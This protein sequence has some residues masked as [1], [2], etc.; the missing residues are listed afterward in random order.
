MEESRYFCLNA[1][2]KPIG[3]FGISQLREKLA[4]GTIQPDSYVA[5]VGGSAWVKLAE[6]LP[7]LIKRERAE[8]AV[9]GIPAPAFPQRQEYCP[10]CGVEQSS[11]SDA[12]MLRCE[13]CQRELAPDPRSSLLA[14]F[15]SS[16]RRY[17]CFKG[18][19]TRKEFWSFYIAQSLISVV[20]TL[21]I[22]YITME[23]QPDASPAELMTAPLYKLF[24]A[25]SPTELAMHIGLLVT[26]L[27]LLLPYIGVAVRRFHDTGRMAFV[28]VIAI[29]LGFAVQLA[30]HISEAA[31][32]AVKPYS[33]IASIF[34]L[35]LIVIAFLDSHRGNN[36]FGPSSKYPQQKN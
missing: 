25:M 29:A 6:A 21:P 26:Q 33:P 19:A 11:H 31:A 34:F 9:E 23:Q 28:P 2:K 10:C 24:S 5:A 18:R 36:P 3:P 27:L 17:A 30:P 14:H 8:V 4:M 12:P 20:F 13:S 7:E 16:L 22:A 35:V 32:A 1:E 15:L